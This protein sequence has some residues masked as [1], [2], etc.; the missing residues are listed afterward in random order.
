MMDD[1]ASNSAIAGLD[2]TSLDNRTLNVNE[3][4]PKTKS[5]N[6]I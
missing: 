5:R 1:A 3:A 2:G 6:W 4:K